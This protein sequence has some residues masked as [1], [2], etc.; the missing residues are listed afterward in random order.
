MNSPHSPLLTSHSASSWRW[1]VCGI[2][3]LAT[4]LN[5]MDRQ[6]LSETATELKERYKLDDARYGKVEQCFSYAFATGGLLF[7]FLTDRFGPRRLYPVVLIGWSLA[8]IATTFA[9]SP[10]AINL[11]TSPDDEPGTG[12]FRWL[13]MCRTILGLFEAGHWPCALITARQVLAAKDR[14]FGNSILQSGA[15]LGAV[16]T[17]LYVLLVRSLGG[18]WQIVFWTIG[19]FG[20]LWVPLWFALIRKGSLDT[21]PAP[22]APPDPELDEAGVPHGSPSTPPERLDVIGFLR[23]YAVLAVTVT[24]LALSWQFI[25]AWLP[26]YLKEFHHYEPG[27]SALAVALYYIT[28]DIGCILAGLLVK[29]LVGRN[30]NVHTSRVMVFAIWCGLTA[31]AVAVPFLGSSFW[32]LVPVLMLVGAGILGLHPIYYALAQEL[33][34]KHMGVLA[35]SLSA[36]TWISVGTL[37]GEIG[38][39]IKATGDYTPGFIVAGLAPLAALLTMLVLWKPAGERPA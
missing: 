9:A 6:A 24:C 36:M 20:L 11:L 38:A 5:Y 34:S 1:W 30:R 21:K 35:G 3:L 29:L 16:L 13:L 22:V 25:R 37:Q 23:R 18:G 17:P 4:L 39:H 12:T 28:A 32:I 14:P 33:P 19:V 15:S 27:A 10:D 26:K 2:L 8:G 31:L 7:G